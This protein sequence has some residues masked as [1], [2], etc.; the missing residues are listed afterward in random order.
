VRDLELLPCH[1]PRRANL[2]RLHPESTVFVVK[3]VSFLGKNPWKEA[4][5]CPAQKASVRSCVAS[6]EERVLLFGVAMQIAVNPDLP[7][8]FLFDLLHEV[9]DG[10]DFRM[11]F[12]LW[13]DPLSVEV[14][15][16]HGVS[17]IANYDSVWI[18]ARYQNKSVEPPQVLRFPRIGSNEVIN[19]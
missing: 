17:V 1:D 3:H 15:T 5:D 12:R 9:F 16:C 6:V 13:V 2:V 4:D 10:H 14:Y 7:F 11:E 19:A 8:I 18:H